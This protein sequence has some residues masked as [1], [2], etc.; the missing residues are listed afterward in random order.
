MITQLFLQI[1][2]SNKGFVH[3][4]ASNIS[5]SQTEF[6]FMIKNKYISN[7]DIIGKDIYSLATGDSHTSRTILFK[8]VEIGGLTLENVKGS[9][10]ENPNASLL[11]GQNFLSRFGKVII[12][13][14][15][16][17]LILINN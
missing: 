12:D 3:T 15:K 7:Q 9:F 13:N 10:S 1:C 8:K 5:L 11:L 4:G 14:E 17:Q 16:K 2:P 6:D